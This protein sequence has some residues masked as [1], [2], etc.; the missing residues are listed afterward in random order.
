MVGRFSW[1]MNL[2]HVSCMVCVVFVVGLGSLVCSWDAGRVSVV[3]RVVRADSSLGWGR[4]LSPVCSLACTAFALSIWICVCPDVV[5]CDSRILVQSLTPS[6]HRG[7]KCFKSL[8]A[9]LRG[10]HR[11]RTSLA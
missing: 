9:Y 3:A 8:S 2:C 6:S 7:A 1:L 4:G 5:G 10:W 11:A